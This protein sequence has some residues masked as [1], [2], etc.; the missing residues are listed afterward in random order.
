M[1]IA[2]IRGPAKR[3]QGTPDEVERTF[4]AVVSEVLAL[5]LTLWHL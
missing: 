2:D 4:Y 3:D 5:G 1:S